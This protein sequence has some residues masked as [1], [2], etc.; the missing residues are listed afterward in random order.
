MEQAPLGADDI[1]DLV[2]INMK[3]P[4]Y[5]GHAY[6]PDSPEI[7]AT[8]NELDRQMTRLLELLDRKAGPGQSV[9]VVTADHGMPP[10]PRDGR[11][12]YPDEIVAAIHARFD[13]E[14]KAI[15]KYYEDAAN[16]EIFIDTARLA[17][18][19][20]SLKDVAAHLLALPYFTA[21]FTEDEVRAAYAQLSRA[22]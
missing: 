4:D 13:P 7:Q 20:F 15:V 16:N 8:L 18:R 9:V 5:T 21:I 19:G 14:A 11:R 2:L 22:R 10:A 1:T 17:S 3:G 12:V 6:G